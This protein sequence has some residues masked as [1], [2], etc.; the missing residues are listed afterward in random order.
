MTKKGVGDSNP[1]QIQAAS[2][3]EAAVEH[4][5]DHVEAIQQGIFPARIP[6]CSNSCPLYCDF[7]GI[8]RERQSAR[9]GA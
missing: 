6:N 2:R 3:I 4:A 7:G 1:T 8:C 9:E 5:L